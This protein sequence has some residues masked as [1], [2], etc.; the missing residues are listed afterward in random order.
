MFSQIIDFILNHTPIF[1]LTQ[2]VWRDEAFSYF[3]AKPNILQVIV[4][5]ANDFNPPLYYLLLNLWIQIF[6]KTDET[7]R[8]LS[9]LFHLLT[10]YL[11][12]LFA[13]RI[14]S[15]K[16]AFFVA[17]FTLFNPMLLYYAFEIRMYSLFVLLTLTSSYSLYIKKWRLYIVSTALGLYTHSF[18]LFVFLSHVLYVLKIHKLSR[19]T[20]IIIIKPFFFYLPWLPILVWQF[21][22]SKDS[23]IFP[24][25]SQL[26]K[27]VLGNL[28]T[29]FEGT[30]PSWWRYT[31]YISLFI[32]IFIIIGVK[33]N[34]KLSLLFV[35]PIF[36]PLFT[37]L[38]YSLIRR[39]IYV[40]RY[41]IFI[42]IFE[43]MAVSLGVF[44]IKNKLLRNVV[45]IG[46]L[47]FVIGF[48]ITIIPYH[49]KTDFKLTFAEINKKATSYDFVYSKTPIGFLESAYY[50]VVPEK[51]F[52]YNPNR[53][54]IPNYIGIT[55]VLK[56]PSAQNF[57]PP[58]SRT[59]LVADD[60]SYE[61]VIS[62]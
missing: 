18:F 35:L 9:F 1:Y 55:A 32:A 21:L 12:Y 51:V 7:L 24:V 43:I 42:T 40:N 45:M 48:N 39:P 37:V 15:K 50:Y 52:V 62:R 49:K 23:W 16:F 25:D 14:F 33:R 57:P 46:W 60:A 20:A 6:G 3:L 36:L 27:S 47:I 19:R 38:V 58:P 4:N 10:V 22:R 53:V 61:V 54:T 8:M 13:K 59:F 56:D 30:P 31:A 28:F 5:T 11:A 29:N 34:K 44:S 17:A 41:M 2:S 26:I